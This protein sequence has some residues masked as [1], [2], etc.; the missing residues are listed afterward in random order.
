MPRML[1]EKRLLCLDIRRESPFAL[2]QV[3][4]NVEG[5]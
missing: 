5:A 1:D 3:T 2:Q 4:N